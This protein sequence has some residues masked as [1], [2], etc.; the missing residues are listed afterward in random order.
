MTRARDRIV[1]TRG[2][3]LA[4]VR[5]LNMLRARRDRRLEAVLAELDAIGELDASIANW[6]QHV[7]NLG[8]I[9]A[10]AM[11][12]RRAANARADDNPF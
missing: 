7:E 9:L 2:L 5:A 11:D 1:K 10:R 12:E 8:R 4:A 6:S 3:M